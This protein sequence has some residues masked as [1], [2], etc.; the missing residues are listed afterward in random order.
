MK[1]NLF[2]FLLCIITAVLSLTPQNTTKSK[3]TTTTAITTRTTKATT[4]TTTTSEYNLVR[5]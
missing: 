1:K 5:I 4:T 3:V 2:I